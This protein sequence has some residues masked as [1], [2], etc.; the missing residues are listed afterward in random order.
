MLGQ[1]ARRQSSVN[2]RKGMSKMRGFNTVAMVVTLGVLLVGCSGDEP[3]ADSMD[4]NAVEQ[5][6]P[7]SPA[8]ASPASAKAE[9][10]TAT[11]ET[12]QLVSAKVKDPG[13]ADH[14]KYV[15]PEFVDIYHS[16]HSIT[17]VGDK[18]SEWPWREAPRLGMKPLMVEL[19]KAA[20]EWRQPGIGAFEQRD[21]ERTWEAGWQAALEEHTAP[22]HLK[23]ELA[24]TYNVSFLSTYDFDKAGFHL[25]LGGGA[26]SKDELESIVNWGVGDYGYGIVNA[27][28]FVRV[29]DES[30][31]R[32]IEEVRRH[33]DLIIKIYGGIVEAKNVERRR[34]TYRA[35]VADYH[36]GELT[37]QEGE[38]LLT[39]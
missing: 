22:Q 37:T 18:I 23:I 6:A 26:T 25:E 19:A 14:A 24:S 35:V 11:P 27:P 5:S 8:D 34:V 10:G 12:P 28:E 29:E 32:R 33:N 17:G 21:L 15:D 9:Q 38:V 2:K 30:L 39:F 1:C 20:D 16:Y 7:A 13:K 4:A 3:A 36:F 31:A